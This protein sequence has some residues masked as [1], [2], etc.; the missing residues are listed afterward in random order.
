M[1]ISDDIVRAAL[2]EY[3]LA[4]SSD[5]RNTDELRSRP[6]VMEAMRRDAMREALRVAFVSA[7]RLRDTATKGEP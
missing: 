4:L 7:S 6:A 5:P 3:S 1:Y 2:A